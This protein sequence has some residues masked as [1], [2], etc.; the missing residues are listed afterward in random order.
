M[1]F[2]CGCWFFFFF[3]FSC[4]LEAGNLTVLKSEANNERRKRRVK[5][6]V[7]TQRKTQSEVSLLLKEVYPWVYAENS[8]SND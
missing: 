4:H 2:V 5:D 7:V 3:S 8:L 1:H 6:L